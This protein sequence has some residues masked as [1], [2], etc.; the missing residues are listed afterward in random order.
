LAKAL[1]GSYSDL[2]WEVSHIGGDRFAGN[3]VLM[4]MG[5]YYG[6]V[7]ADSAP[8]LVEE[9]LSGRVDLDHFRGRSTLAPAA[10][11]AEILLR[12]RLGHLALTGLRLTGI[13]RAPERWA[14]TFE[15]DGVAW[16]C[17]VA[18][19]KAEPTQLTCSAT[20]T[21]PAPTFTGIDIARLG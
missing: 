9:Y 12:K 4:P 11:A 1:Q 7:T 13:E 21:S 18:V 6:R 10:Q 16:R 5:L 2:V 14:V 17:D 8:R 19:G 20:R 15:V 3:V